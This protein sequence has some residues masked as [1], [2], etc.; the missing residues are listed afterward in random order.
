MSANKDSFSIDLLPVNSDG[1]LGT[2]S[3]D[4]K[5]PVL[6]FYNICYHV[7]EKRG[8]L[9]KQKITE[10]R[11]LSDINGIMNPGLNAIVGP[12]VAGNTL[13]LD[14]LAARKDPR[15]I[16]GDVWV[17]E[18]PE[19]SNI[20]YNTGYVVQDDVVMHTL[21]V[22]ENLWFSAALR[23]PTTMTK[24][25]K[26]ERINN[27]IKELDLEELADSKVE[28]KGERKKTSIGMELILDPCILFLDEPTTGL[29]GKT[30]NDVFTLLKR[31]SQQGRTIIFT[32]HQPCYSIFRLFDSLTI[33][34]SGELMYHGPAQKALEYFQSAGFPCKFYSNP[35]ELFLDIT[36]GIIK[37]DSEDYEVYKTEMCS[38]TDDSEIKELAIHFSKSTFYHDTKTELEER[39]RDENK[40]CLVRKEIPYVTSFVHQ[41][42]GLNRRSF[43]NFTGNPQY[44]ATLIISTFVVGLVTGV[45][46]IL[47]KDICSEIHNRALMLFYLMSYQCG[48]SK[49]TVQHFVLQKKR[50]VHESTSGYYRVSSYFFGSLLSDLLLEMFLTSFVCICTLYFIVVSKPGVETFFI[51]FLT[52]LVL[53]F[54]SI[55]ITLAIV[56]GHTDGNTAMRITDSYFTFMM[57][58]LGLSLY[59]GTRTTQLSWVQYFS[60]PYYG[61]M[62]LQHNEF[63]GRNFCPSLN[64]TNDNNCPDYVI[65]FGE[66]FLLM[67]D[68]D[69]SSW[70]LWKNHVALNILIFIFLIIAYLRMLYLKRNP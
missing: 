26:K 65:C 40:R 52:L 32:I 36:D 4:Q 19:D 61:F 67:Q 60:I 41:L 18:V 15:G 21:S 34:A 27:I 55:S 66:E 39:S 23:L 63:L 54:S 25:E 6:C 70:G 7:K 58:L 48:F 28:S 56:A 29:D 53:A 50:F 12:S 5:G 31:I 2:T 8:F 69:L 43:Q 33:L 16:S 24:Q 14:I 47:L 44:W 11:I 1:F 68:M 13:L 42:I 9:L 64:I 49:W 57:I 45:M 35:A 46:F 10:K 17:H 3:S 20:P 37:R 51:M 30:A 62:A 22:R 38:R 59:F